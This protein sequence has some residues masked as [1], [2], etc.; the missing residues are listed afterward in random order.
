MVLLALPNEIA[1]LSETI[2]TGEKGA[3]LFDFMGNGTRMAMQEQRDFPK[4][5]LVADSCFNGNA[6]GES[7]LLLRK[8]TF[9]LPAPFR[10]G[11]G[12]TY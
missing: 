9:H 8:I 3:I 11:S 4:R 6:V 7:H 10:A 12:R 5:V 1:V 2:A